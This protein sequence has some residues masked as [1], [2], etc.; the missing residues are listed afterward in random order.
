LRHRPTNDHLFFD[1]T[2][3]KRLFFCLGLLAVLQGLI[4]PVQA[5]NRCS[6]QSPAHAVA[7]LELYT[8]E[9]CSSCPP[10]DQFVSALP[11][12]G[13]SAD[14]A[15]ILSLHVDYWNDLGW[16]D[17][18]SRAEFTQR[19]RDLSAL[20]GSRTIYTPEFYIGA[21]EVRNNG[22]GLASNVMAAIRRINGA[23]ARADIAIALGPVGAAGLPVDIRASAVQKSKL[24]VALVESGLSNDVRAGEN[25]GRVLKHDFVVRQW[26]APVS[27]VAGSD[28]KHAIAFS[29]VLALPPGAAAGRLAVSAF[30]ETDEG[31]VLQALSLPVCAN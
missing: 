16:K 29:R 12:A 2:M 10:A 17:R 8:S 23:P 25:G 15:V 27:L 3:M 24:H 6:K 20:A 14:Q 13:V 26:L 7:L 21:R 28:G 30:V 11:A 19:Q 1:R 18:F 22:L 5:A 31:G 4:N 9:G